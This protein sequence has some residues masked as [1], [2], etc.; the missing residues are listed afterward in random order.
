MYYPAAGGDCSTLELA[1]YYHYLGCI[2]DPGAP[3]TA[4]DS[5][6]LDHRYMGYLG[7]FTLKPPELPQL[8]YPGDT[9]G[10]H[11]GC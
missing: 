8:F 1:R 4:L 9:R 7:E 11:Y 2:G 6:L 10:L 3:N 5:Q